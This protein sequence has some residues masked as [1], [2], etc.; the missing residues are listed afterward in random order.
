M[1]FDGAQ[2]PDGGGP[3]AAAGASLRQG[4][5]DAAKSAAAPRLWPGLAPRLRSRRVRALASNSRRAGAAHLKP[6]VDFSESTNY[7][8]R[9]I[10]PA[11][12][13]RQPQGSSP[14]AE[15]DLIA[16]RAALARAVASVCPP[17]L[18]ASAEDLVQVALLRVVD[19]CRRADGST[20]FSTAYLRKAAYSA[21][22]DEIRRL[23]RRREV[24][25]EDESVDTT[26]STPA[27]NPEQAT[28]ARQQGRAIRACLARLVR[29]RRL[30]VTL[31][32]VGHSVPEAARLL[33]WSTK[34]AENLVYRGLA[35][36]RRCLEAA[37]MA[38]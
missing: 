23:K 30:A 22:V 35:D 17:W 4:P 5:S 11:H 27:A 36:L 26:H 33:S 34:R 6:V 7:S 25:L 9:T 32:L 3:A 37:G 24:P 1:S 21:L 18:A 31:H 19:V 14:I 2:E 12:L 28:S 38:R 8:T 10:E 15:A 16:L 20:D 13:E 29:P